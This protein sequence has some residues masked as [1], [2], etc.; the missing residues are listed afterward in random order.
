MA[1]S[2]IFG[3]LGDLS[4]RAVKKISIPKKAVAKL[5]P[6]VTSDAS[7]VATKTMKTAKP[8]NW[9]TPAKV[10]GGTAVVTGSLGIAKVGF[11]WTQDARAL[12]G[13]VSDKEQADSILD[14][15]ERE[16]KINDSE[17]QSKQD[18]INFL[19]DKNLLDGNFDLAGLS[20]ENFGG[21]E[22]DES[23]SESGSPWLNIALIGGGVAGA[24]ILAN[25]LSKKR[26]KIVEKVGKK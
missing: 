21:M 1:I 3:A 26:K 20:G 24:L 22:L 5:T 8:I 25:N 11:D 14:N 2:K 17:R 10:L 12:V 23:S 19:D 7:K 13:L 15:M 6:E 4:K 18:W 16:Q 9:R